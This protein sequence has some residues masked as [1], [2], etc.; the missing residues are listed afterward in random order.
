MLKNLFKH[1][2]YFIIFF[3]LLIVITPYSFAFDYKNYGRGD[4]ESIA[5]VTGIIITIISPPKYRIIIIGTVLGL[6]FSYF[7]YKYIVPILINF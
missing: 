3:L 1:K 5:I 6:I 7:T 4:W 2:E